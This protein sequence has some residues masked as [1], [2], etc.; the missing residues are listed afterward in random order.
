MTLA[1][2]HAQLRAHDW[3]FQYSDDGRV[4]REGREDAARLAEATTSACTARG[5]TLNC[6]SSLRTSPR[7][8]RSSTCRD[9]V[10]RVTESKRWLWTRSRVSDISDVS[11]QQRE[12]VMIAAD[13]DLADLAK[14]VGPMTELELRTLR[15]SL[16]EFHTGQQLRDIPPLIMSAH[17]NHALKGLPDTVPGEFAR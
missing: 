16:A 4:Y 10:E 3:F 11:C 2:F 1:E 13:M 12:R 17:I 9:A 6:I 7:F 5:A 8:A 15:H 14:V